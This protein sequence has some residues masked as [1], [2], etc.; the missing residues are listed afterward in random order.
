MLY[1]EGISGMPKA[2][3]DLTNSIK[4]QKIA[5]I[6]QILLFAAGHLLKVGK[7]KQIIA[8]FVTIEAIELNTKIVFQLLISF[9]PIGTGLLTIYKSLNLST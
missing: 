5:K 2:I 3:P 4:I 9:P 6:S 1:F 8:A 7:V